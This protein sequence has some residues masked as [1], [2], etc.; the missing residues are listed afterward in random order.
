MEKLSET[1]ISTE[2][3][4]V[5]PE[6]KPRKCY[7]SVPMS[8]RSLLDVKLQ[9]GR[10]SRLLTEQGWAVTT[11]L[12]LMDESAG[13]ADNLCADLRHI[14]TDTDCVFFLKNAC[15]SRGCQM[16]REACKLYG[17]PYLDLFY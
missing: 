13:Y 3:Q 4:F 10:A 2:T 6:G 9:L 14:L 17:I 15:S 11:P 7:L 5:G 12:D 8:G 1:R 16:E